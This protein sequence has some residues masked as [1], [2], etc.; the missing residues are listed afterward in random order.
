[1]DIP[2][3]HTARRLDSRC[4]HRAVEKKMDSDV[5]CHVPHPLHPR[6]TQL[7]LLLEGKDI[8]DFL[9]TKEKKVT[10]SARQKNCPGR[11]ERKSACPICCPSCYSPHS[12]L[13]NAFL[14]E[15]Y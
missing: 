3:P 1:M 6:P 14:E 15:G 4:R 8:P 2:E 5:R 11:S 9:K 13:K 10:D 12:H 7:A